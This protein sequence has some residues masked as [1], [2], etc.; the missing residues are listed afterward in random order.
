MDA[1]T[2]PLDHP[3]LERQQLVEGETPQGGVSIVE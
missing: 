2:P 1:L 3:D